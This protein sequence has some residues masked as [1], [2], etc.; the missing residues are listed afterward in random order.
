MVAHVPEACTMMM[1][2]I[3]PFGVY[4]YGYDVCVRADGWKVNVFD[5]MILWGSEGL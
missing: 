2:M 3:P 5:R 4:G 1:M